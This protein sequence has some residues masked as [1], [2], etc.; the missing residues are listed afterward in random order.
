[1]N[2][3]GRLFVINHSTYPRVQFVVPLAVKFISMWRSTIQVSLSDHDT[4]SFK[5]M[6][7]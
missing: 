2:R 7:K 6:G 3:I 4:D 1:M 5:G